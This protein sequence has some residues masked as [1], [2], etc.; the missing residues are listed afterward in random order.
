MRINLPTW[1]TLLRLVLVPAIAVLLFLPA[2]PGRNLIAAGLFGLAFFTDWLDGWL[3]RRWNQTSHFGAF[4][5]PVAD[6]LIVCVVL[7]LLIYHDPRVVV[8]VPAIVIIGRE[9]TVSALREWM[10]ELG[11][12][13]VVA[14][15]TAGKYKT[16]IQMFAILIMLYALPHRGAFYDVGILLLAAAALLTL[17]SMLRYLQAAWPLLAADR[18]RPGGDR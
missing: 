12:R 9:I 14:V 1:L 15:G 7:T 4:L 5:D 18:K 6:K 2:F 11:Q 3:A 17:W 10:A 13:G 16:T 8:A